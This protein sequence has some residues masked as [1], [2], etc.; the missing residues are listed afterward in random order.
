MLRNVL[1]K[2]HENQEEL[3]H[4]W[5]ELEKWELEDEQEQEQEQEQEKKQEVDQQVQGD[6]NFIPDHVLNGNQSQPRQRRMQIKDHVKKRRTKPFSYSLSSLDRQGSAARRFYHPTVSLPRWILQWPIL[7]SIAGWVLFLMWTYIWIRFFVALYELVTFLLMGKKR[8]LL[9]ELRSASSY[10]E[11]VAIAKKL[12][13]L[14]KYDVWK[15]INESPYYDSDTIYS[16]IEKLERGREIRDLNLLLD[17]LSSIYNKNLGGLGLDSVGLYSETYF[18]TKKLVDR[19]VQ[20]VIASTLLIYEAPEHVMTLRDKLKFFRKAK[21][22]YGNTAL[23]LSSGGMLALYSI[24]VVKA[25]YDEHLLPRIFSGSS[26]GAMVASL[27]CTRT[28]E[29]L[30]DFFHPSLCRFIT[31]CDEPWLTLLWRYLVTGAVFSP[32]RFGQAASAMTF[33]NMTFLEAYE[34]TGRILNITVSSTLRHGA[35]VMLNHITTPHVCIWSAVVAS[36]AMP[37]LLPPVELY[38]KKPGVDHISVFND[39]GKVFCDGVLRNDIPKEEL[40]HF[41]NVNFFIVS[42]MNPHVIPFLFESK[43]SSGDPSL[44]RQG[45]SSGLRGGFMLSTLEALLRLEM[46]KWLVLIEEMDLLPQIKNLDFSRFLLQTFTGDVT[47]YPKG[48]GLGIIMD[49]MRVVSNPTYR[50][51]QQYLTGGAQFTWPK[52]AQIHNHYILER[53][54]VD[55]EEELTLKLYTSQES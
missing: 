49:Y 36:S 29:E 41:F 21:Q 6:V 34:K 16:L 50:W 48:R 5:E 32:S 27:V 23:C 54:L 28:D 42:Q 17:T 47:I 46:R 18:G 25:L 55:C 53:I 35:P 10:Q 13:V 4:R 40:S 51:M 11:Y 39:F 8:R 7:F 43:G 33:G 3:H 52:L 20:N 14:E 19:L 12:D 30:Q 31:P 26:A 45:N 37:S 38:Q 15:K 9:L 2:M 1:Q 44:R 24:G 22:A